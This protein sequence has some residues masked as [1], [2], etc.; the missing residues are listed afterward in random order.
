MCFRFPDWVGAFVV[1]L[2]VASGATTHEPALRVCAD[3]DNLP[4]SNRAQQ[5]FENRIAELLA[6]EMHRR[7]DYHWSRQGRGFIRSVLNAH[8]CDLLVAV[9][10]QFPPVLTTPAYYRSTYVF[11]SRKD[12]KLGVR[13]FDDPLLNKLKIGV[14]ILD[15]DYAPPGQALARRGLADCIVGFDSFGND[16]GEIISAVAKGKI[17]LAVVWGPLAA[18]Y[19]RRQHAALILEPVSPALDPPALPFQYD[20]A[21]GVRKTDKPLRDQLTVI[22]ERRTKAIKNILREYRVPQISSGT[23]SS[24]KVGGR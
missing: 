12:R 11:V 21:M 10:K 5:G 16:A 6:K 2:S 1:L 18:Y 23:I 13:S 9:P 24:A 4:Y 8:E 22:L 20:I 19:A 14:Q 7:L 3:P 17:D 15:D